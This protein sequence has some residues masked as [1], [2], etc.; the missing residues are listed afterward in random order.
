MPGPVLLKRHVKGTKYD[1]SVQVVELI[2]AN[3]QYAHI[4]HSNGREDTVSVRHLAPRGECGEASVNNNS[5]QT[6]HDYSNVGELVPNQCPVT[7]LGNSED[8]SEDGIQ[9]S[10]CQEI[11]ES[12]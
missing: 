10:Q 12:E 3:P 7:P 5:Q 4:R 6:D 11:Q 1:S 8:S 9:D 2:Q